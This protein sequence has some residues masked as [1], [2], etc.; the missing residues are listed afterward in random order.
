MTEEQASRASCS[1]TRA[2]VKAGSLQLN[3]REQPSVGDSASDDHRP[4][5][6]AA[7]PF[8]PRPLPR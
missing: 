5:A 2:A 3:A 1:A 4:P 6:E 7:N 8:R